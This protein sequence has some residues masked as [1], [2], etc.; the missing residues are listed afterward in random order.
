MQS[1][2][3]AV[4]EKVRLA[5]GLYN[6]LVLI[7]GG[8]SGGNT[9]SLQAVGKCIG[10]PIVNVNL[11]LSRRLLDLAERQRPLHVQQLLEQI[12][13]ETES[14]IVLLNRIELL[15]DVSLRQDPLRLLQYL[16]RHMT[17]IAAWNGSIEDRCL[18]YSQPGH[19]E[20]RCYPIDGILTVRM[21]AAT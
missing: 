12:V 3:E 21:Q 6:R 11:E 14:D 15:F 5:R 10:V 9:D 16:S 1:L 2:A 18:S 20:Y 17:V 4:N 19:P 8:Q 7:V 13:S